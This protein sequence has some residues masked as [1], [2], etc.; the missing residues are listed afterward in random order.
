MVIISFPALRQAV[1]VARREPIWLTGQKATMMIAGVDSEETKRQQKTVENKEKKELAE[2]K[3]AD[4]LK[5]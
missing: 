2:K 3:A 5:Y 4:K 1:R